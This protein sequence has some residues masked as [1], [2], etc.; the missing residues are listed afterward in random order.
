MWEIALSSFAAVDSVLDFEAALTEEIGESIK[1]V[2]VERGRS[3]VKQCSPEFIAAYS[4]ALDGQVERRLQQTSQSIGDL[5]YSAWIDAGEPA[6]P[7]DAESGRWQRIWRW[8][9]D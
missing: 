8:L 9:W 6:L 1:F 7:A 3:I 2:Y 4:A 5:W